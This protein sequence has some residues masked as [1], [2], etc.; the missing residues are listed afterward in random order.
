MR[1]A[2]VCVLLVACGG[3][4][5]DDDAGAAD[6]ALVDAGDDAGKPDAGT[7]G[8]AGMGSDGGSTDAGNDAGLSATCGGKLPFTCGLTRFCDYESGCGFADETGLCADIPT[9]CDDVLMPVCGCDGVTYDNACFANMAGQDTMHDGPC[10]GSCGP[11]E[12][13]GEG[14][15]RMLLGWMWDGTD[16]ISIGGCNCVGADCDALFATEEDCNLLY[17]GCIVRTPCVASSDCA[18]TEWCDFADGA[19][20]G[21]DG[22][23]TPRPDACV[24]DT[25]VCGCDGITYDSECSANLAGS[26]VFFPAACGDV[27]APRDAMGMGPCDLFLGWTW[28]G[29]MC[30]GLSG[31]SCVG[32]DCDRLYSSLSTC[33]AATAGCRP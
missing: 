4:N 30:R 6:A 7:D 31:C 10:D 25:E 5:E 23:C 17:E 12:A 32:A 20:C 14:P 13:E 28:D 26:D 15:C 18:A 21:G 2:W 11:M 24:G 29:T 16:C 1:I 27:C 3:G 22:V 33:E 19:R 9:A 8:D